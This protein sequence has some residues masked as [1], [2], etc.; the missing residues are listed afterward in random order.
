MK[1]QL[2]LSVW[3]P[4]AFFLFSFTSLSA[5][6][7]YIG[8][9]E[10]GQPLHYS[11]SSDRMYMV[12][13]AG[14]FYSTDDGNSWNNIPLPDTITF[15]NRIFEAN[16]SLYLLNDNEDWHPDLK[17]TAY[18]SDDNGET[19]TN[20]LPPAF[21]PSSTWDLFTA[22][23][24]DT[25]VLVQ[26]ATIASS[27]NKGESY[28]LAANFPLQPH[29][30]FFHQDKL[31][32][33][34]FNTLSSSS[35][36]GLT[37]DLLYT[38]PDS[39]IFFTVASVGDKLYKFEQYW[40]AP[41][42]TAYFYRSDDNGVSWEQTS[43]FD[44]PFF[45]TPTIIG[46]PD[47]IYLYDA[48]EGNVIYHSTDGGVTWIPR[49]Q[50]HYFHAYQYLNGILSAIERTGYGG[51]VWLSHNNGE[52]FQTFNTGFTGADCEEIVHGSDKLWVNANSS[53]FK[54]ENVNQWP[55]LEYFK[56]IASGDGTHF[57]A[58]AS[59]VLKRSSDGGE[60]WYSIPSSL[61][62]QPDH[63]QF[64]KIS[65]C[66]NLFFV[67]VLNMD[68]YSRDFGLTWEPVDFLN[69]E[70]ISAVSYDDPTYVIAGDLGTVM[71][72]TDGENWEDI[73]YDIWAPGV[74]SI[75][76]LHRFGDFTF[77]LVGIGNVS[78]APGSTT[79]DHIVVNI[80]EG[81]FSAVEDLVDITH[82][83][84]V[85]IGCVYGHGVFISLDNGYYWH[86]FNFG[87]TDFQAKDIEIIDDQIYLAVS[88]GMWIRPVSDLAL[89][90]FSGTVFN[91]ENENGIQDIT[92][93]GIENILVRKHHENSTSSTL[94]DGSFDIYSQYNLL[95]TLSA[96]LPS[97]Y[98]V[99]T[100]P[101][102]YVT[103][104][105]SNLSIGIHF[106]PGIYDAA[107][108]I[109]NNTNFRPGF[110]STITL[111]YKNKGT[112][113]TD[114]EIKFVLADEL[115]YLSSSPD[116]LF[117]LDTLRWIIQDVA[118][119]ESGNI[120]IEVKTDVSVP[121]GTPILLYAFTDVV[122]DGDAN[123][124]DNEA[125]LSVV[126]VGSYDPNDKAVYP[127]GFITPAMI[128]DTQR[129]E[130]TIRFQNTGNFPA[131]FIRIQDTLSANL[132]LA[133]LEIIAASH[134][135]TWKLLPNNVLDFFFDDINL[136][137]STN[138]ERGSHGFV[139]FAINAKSTLQ[140]TDKI[141][142]KAYIYFDFNTPVITNTVGSTVGFETS[143]KE[144]G[145]KLTITASP[146]PTKD[147]IM[148]TI[149]DQ[150]TNGDVIL[151]LYDANGAFVKT[152][153]FTSPDNIRM[154]IQELP[155]GVYF[156]N[157]RVG[158]DHGTIGILKN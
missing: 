33:T 140:L 83:E 79:W 52:S 40:N 95:D 32:F 128:A 85:L 74:G 129:L 9:P 37:W 29:N 156:L 84:N 71:K 144:P 49:I 82:F 141:E 20:I 58:Y 143:I 46:D 119:F 12:A 26:T 93:T 14:L 105:D 148:V 108:Y 123:Q 16:G 19:W 1:N 88:G 35:D 118:P 90:L 64:G 120:T 142:N 121:I 112:E 13:T 77:G 135:F 153:T 15:F 2:T 117:L 104:P 97:P 114:L 45:G 25:I 23:K 18:R 3:L 130:Y 103:E 150:V 96:V 62:N 115:E 5:Q 126:V 67:H 137:D 124:E 57:L 22:I 127:S 147:F 72:S 102:V 34:S 132:D 100:T 68:W 55:E 65:A 99:I 48:N 39:F 27:V 50:D 73:T 111:T 138:D 152:N 75:Q 146:S 151:T 158:R 106:I 6:W 54:N 80:D 134:D 154:D 101:P 78:L 61:F 21:D 41:E 86:P 81:P 43:T 63:S 30:V 131:T 89:F 51:G 60:L 8:S 87:L 149:S 157:A 7:E 38:S 139:K 110:E 66:G 31:L 107:I 47:N 56:N 133:S 98:G 36:L 125:Y 155:S 109:T 4:L 113:T 59:D 116:G 145:K 42:L 10:T 17:S 91:D 70:D 69:N 28:T 94:A 122:N 44:D 24:G 11:Y 76:M 136:P 53:V 92:E